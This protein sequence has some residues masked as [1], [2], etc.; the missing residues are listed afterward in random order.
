M[1]EQPNGP[2]ICIGMICLCCAKKR[3]EKKAKNDFRFLFF[4]L[5]LLFNDEQIFKCLKWAML[6]KEMLDN[7]Q[8]TSEMKCV[9]TLVK[10]STSQKE[11][12]N[13]YNLLSKQQ[14]CR[15][16]CLLWQFDAG[17]LTWSHYICLYKIIIQGSNANSSHLFID[18]LRY[19]FFSVVVA[20]CWACLSRSHYVWY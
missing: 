4:A 18:L 7:N 12:S 2:W 16:I 13:F 11:N 15:P 20:F 17:K 14:Y 3:G 6:Q 10:G 8:C 19:L 5:V 9:G 1:Q